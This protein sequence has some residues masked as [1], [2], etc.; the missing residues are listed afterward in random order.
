MAR[1]YPGD[2]TTGG[3][4]HWGAGGYGGLGGLSSMSGS[5]VNDV[6]GDFKNPNEFGSGADYSRQRHPAGSDPAPGQT[7]VLDGTIKADGAGD[8]SSSGGSGG[9]IRIDAGSITGSATSPQWRWQWEYILSYH[10]QRERCRIALYYNDASG[11]DTSHIQAR[12]GETGYQRGGAGT[13]YL[14]SSAQYMAT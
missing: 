11:F 7:I 6:Y 5:T 4:T 1:A 8:F 9:G 3:S 10:S 12:C 13:I 2:T 14:K